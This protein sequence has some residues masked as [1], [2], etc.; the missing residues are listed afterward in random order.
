MN[1]DELLDLCLKGIE[2]LEENLD[3]EDRSYILDYLDNY[4]KFKN[5]QKDIL[6]KINNNL[7][8]AKK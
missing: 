2:E 8:K 6:N 4:I 1:R 7:E 3:D 5:V